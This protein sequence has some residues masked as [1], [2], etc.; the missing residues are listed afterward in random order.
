MVEDLSKRDG[1]LRGRLFYTKRVKN[2]TQK[3]AWRGGDPATRPDAA[4]GAEP[5]L[6]R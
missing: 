3:R 5:A 4:R 1:R 2:V 6:T